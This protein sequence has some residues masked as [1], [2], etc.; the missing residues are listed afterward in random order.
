MLYK[1]LLDLRTVIRRINQSTRSNNPFVLKALLVN[2]WGEDKSTV[3]DSTVL[4]DEEGLENL[5]FLAERFRHRWVEKI[6]GNVIM[7]ELRITDTMLPTHTYNIAKC[8]Y[9]TTDLDKEEVASGHITHKITQLLENAAG[10]LNKDLICTG[11][12]LNKYGREEEQLRSSREREL[13]DISGIRSSSDE[14][15]M[16]RTTGNMER[17]S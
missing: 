8:R 2:P 11:L 16:G 14:P 9:V 10:L 13:R 4:S 1:D 7:I 12:I 17:Y 15:H 3:V 6:P 5:P